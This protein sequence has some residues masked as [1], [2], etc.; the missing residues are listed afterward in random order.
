M[1]ILKAIVYR[2]I[3]ILLLL[4]VSYFVLGNITAALSISLIDAVIATVYYYYFDKI[5]DKF[6][7]K[8]EHY[9]LEYKYRKMK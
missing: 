1:L 9:K 7:K 8:I 4:L 6:E 3:R 5:W 2:I